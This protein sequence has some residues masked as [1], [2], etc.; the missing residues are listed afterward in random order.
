MIQPQQANLEVKGENKKE[1]FEEASV[2]RDKALKEKQ[3]LMAGASEA[4]REAGDKEK[5]LKRL[6]KEQWE[7]L[8]QV[9]AMY[10]AD[11]RRYL[12]VPCTLGRELADLVQSLLTQLAPWP[13]T[14]MAAQ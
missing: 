13:S 11:N 1:M 10:V 2:R 7:E 4:E 3:A 8:N 9:H 12:A 14:A 5:E 6:L